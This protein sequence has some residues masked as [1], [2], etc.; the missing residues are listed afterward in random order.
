MDLC[1][2]GE[3]LTWRRP[4][5]LLLPCWCVLERSIERAPPRH[6]AGTPVAASR[7]AVASIHLYCRLW[8]ALDRLASELHR[9]ES[10]IDMGIVTFRL[11]LLVLL[12][13]CD[14][15]RWRS[16]LRPE[17]RQQLRCT[18]ARVLEDLAAETLDFQVLGCA[19]NR[20][21]DAVLDHARVGYLR[22]WADW[23]PR[24]TERPQSKVASG[25]GS[26]HRCPDLP[27]RSAAA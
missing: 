20:L 24:V 1:F 23:G 13:A 8:L 10:A 18:L 27:R 12:D 17:E 2:M 11:E 21:L 22:A 26:G 6:A 7:F 16:M 5:P 9:T 3:G 14:G 19:Q 25:A 15:V 4:T